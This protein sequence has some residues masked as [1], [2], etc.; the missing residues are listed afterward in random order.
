MLDGS[1]KVRF[2]VRIP[3]SITLV[4]DDTHE[5]EKL[6]LYKTTD[7]YKYVVK[8]DSFNVRLSHKRTLDEQG[9]VH[10]HMYEEIPISELTSAFAEINGVFGRSNRYGEVEF[11]GINDKFALYPSED[12]YPSENLYPNEGE[13]G[14]IANAT[15]YLTLWTD[16][17]EV[18]P[19]GRVVV[20]Y[21]DKEGE[22]QTY[23][24][25]FDADAKNTYYMEDNYFLLNSVHTE[26][27]IVE[28]LDTYFVPNITGISYVPAELSMKGLPHIEAGDVLSVLTKE[29]G[30][31]LFVFRRTMTGIKALIDDIEAK[32]DE[33]NKSRMSGITQKGVYE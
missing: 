28:I 22:Y 4:W 3:S 27:E 23:V 29:G 30:I 24:H 31:E 25:E 2:T 7:G 9:G 16:D 21:K 15:H 12:L 8:D 26:E 5:T 32:G 6:W 14:E 20:K 18:Q 19:F 33:V 13:F 10:Y 11:I 17:Y 1:N